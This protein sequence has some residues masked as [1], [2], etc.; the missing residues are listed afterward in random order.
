VWPSREHV[1]QLGLMP[2]HFSFLFLQI[3]H[4]RRFGLGTVEFPRAAPDSPVC[5]ALGSDTMTVSRGEFD[6]DDMLGTWRHDASATG[7]MGW[8]RRRALRAQG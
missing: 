1:L 2:S 8:R 7:G 3:M 4:A 5:S 6:D